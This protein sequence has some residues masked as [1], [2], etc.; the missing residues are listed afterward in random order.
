MGKYMGIFDGDGAQP[1]R[2][3][4]LLEAILEATQEAVDT[5]DIPELQ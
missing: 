5:H 4:N 1:D 2:E 3:N